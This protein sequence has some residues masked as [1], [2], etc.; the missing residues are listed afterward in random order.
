VTH[1]SG[2][3]N[4]NMSVALIMNPKAV[5]WS[6][7]GFLAL[8]STAVLLYANHASIAAYLNFS[9][10]TGKAIA[11]DDGSGGPGPFGSAPLSWWGSRK[12]HGDRMTNP[13]MTA[14]RIAIGLVLLVGVAV[15]LAYFAADA[16][17]IW[18]QFWGRCADRQ[19]I[20][21]LTKEP[22]CSTRD[23]RG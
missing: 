18:R 2:E 14:E 4:S 3:Q 23:P 9:K 1:D 8:L 12:P 11:A 10:P 5:T 6:V 16:G 15:A 21:P 19:R 22:W 20:K 13:I 7:W 17:W